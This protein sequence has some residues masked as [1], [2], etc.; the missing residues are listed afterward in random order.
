MFETGP[1][2]DDAS[3]ESIQTKIREIQQPPSAVLRARLAADRPMHI[4]RVAA[5][6]FL[7]ATILT[8]LLV[9]VVL[10]APLISVEAALILRDLDGSLPLPAPLL[11]LLLAL[12]FGVAWVTAGQAMLAVAYDC[13]LLPDE[14]RAYDKLQQQLELYVGSDSY[15]SDIPESG[16][17]PIHMPGA[18]LRAPTPAPGQGATLGRGKL[19]TPVPTPGG[20]LQYQSAPDPFLAFQSSRG[21][22]AP[23]GRS[24]TPRPV[25]AATPRPTADRGPK[26]TYGNLG[27]PDAP[28]DVPPEASGDPRSGGYVVGPGLDEDL[29]HEG[30]GATASWRAPRWGHI[31]EPWL[32]DAVRK[33]EDLSRRYPV[34]AFLEYS[35]EADLPFTLV[36]ERATP[37]MAVRAMVEFVGFLASIATPKR[38]RI[39]LRSVVHLDRSF[40]RSV[41]SA[42][43]PYFPDTVDIRQNGFRVE[44]T[45][46]EPERCWNRM[47]ILPLE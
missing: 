11:V 44:I 4:A 19:Q 21:T 3:V 36:L 2:V 24:A 38:A 8:A 45:F 5:M 31:D 6:I 39:E 27:S 23:G 15:V 30:A 26:L 34:Q 25:R 22:P 32:L 7:L 17:P 33:S 46:L 16:P 1:T 10:V 47:P 43:E 13:P 28:T 35:V 12:C 18:S 40:Y 9:P 20:T 14:Q 37:A 29:Y 41:M 42:M